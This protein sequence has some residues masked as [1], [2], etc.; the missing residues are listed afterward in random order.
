MGPD[1]RLLE[2]SDRFPALTGAVVLILILAAAL[3]ALWVARRALGRCGSSTAV[4]AKLETP[5][6]LEIVVQK[7][8]TPTK[9]S[10]AAVDPASLVLETPIG[11]GGQGGVWLARDGSTGKQLALKQIRKGRLASLKK[12][13][14]VTASNCQWLLEREA[15]L[16]CSDH[17]FVT[18]C[19][20]TFQDDASLYFA[21]ELAPGGD[22]FSLLH[23][24]EHGRLPEEQARF[25]TGCVALA[26][27][28]IHDQGY[29][30]CDVKLE[31]VLLSPDG[32]AQLCDFGLAKKRPQ[33]APQHRLW[34]S[35][36]GDRAPPRVFTKCGTDQY[37]PPEVVYGEGRSVGADWWALGVLLHEMLTGHSPF[38]GHGMKEIFTRIAEYAKG[39]EGSREALKA[40][41]L[42]DAAGLSDAGADFTMGLLNATEAQRLGCASDGRRESFEKLQGHDWFQPI[43]WSKMLARELAAPYL[44]L[45]AAADDVKEAATDATPP[46]TPV[47]S[48]AV[49][50]AAAPKLS[51]ASTEAI[52]EVSSSGSTSSPSGGSS[53]SVGDDEDSRRG[54]GGEKTTKN[55]PNGS[56]EA[57]EAPDANEPIRALFDPKRGVLRERPY[58]AALWEDLFDPF[59]PRLPGNLTEAF[60]QHAQHAQPAVEQPPPAPTEDKQVAPSS[61]SGTAAFVSV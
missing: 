38:E 1:S 29:L 60:A 33:A 58:D 27:Q 34:P 57:E 32:Y 14:N 11:S 30:Y 53:H 21:L 43:A 42:E 8:A 49:G 61:T 12:R 4:K 56:P 39:G 36:L 46:A 47:P 19:L 10:S 3:G 26:L 52:S 15:L 51:R 45:A 24:S 37:A 55:T 22:L 23:L 31:N 28:H 9:G 20:A 40:E 41:L 48:K 25:Y 13:A 6:P 54:S 7:D 50:G 2:V 5:A 17:P 35:F 44:P 16:A 18:S 59:G